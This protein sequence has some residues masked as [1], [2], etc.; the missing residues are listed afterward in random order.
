M[1]YSPF[2]KALKDVQPDELSILRNVSEGWHVEYKSQMVSQNI[3]AKTISSFANQYGGWLILGV[4]E[5]RA[6]HVAGTFPGIPNAQIQGGLESLRNASRDTVRPSIFFEHRI[7]DGPINAIGLAENFSLIVVQIPQGPNTPYVHNDGRIYRRIADS[8]NPKPETDRATLDLLFQRGVQSRS[9]LEEYITRNPTVSEAEDRVPYL[10]LFILSDPFEFQ[11]HW[12]GGNFRDF[13]EVMKLDMLPFNNIF[14]SSQGFVARQTGND[15]YWRSLTWEFSRRCHSFITVPIPVLPNDNVDASWDTFSIGNKFIE[16]YYSSNLAPARI[17][18]LNVMIDLCAA[19]LT[20]HRHLAYK[21]GV[22]GPFFIKARLDDVWRCV[23]FLDL[24]AYLSQI[25]EFGLPIVQ[26]S[27]FMAPVGTSIDSFHLVG[28]T[29]S[30]SVEEERVDVN[31]IMEISPSILMALGISDE[32][33]LNSS[34]WLASR[35]LKNAA[36]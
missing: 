18:D 21:A 25:Y 5:D 11:G 34:G 26:D 7:F 24:P 12:Y 23:P 2:N 15:P 14:P 3:L 16:K 10:H 33:L 36:G 22:V 19:V 32:T 1:Q 17:L 29:R 27:D 6:A 20:R 30:Q 8:S 35:L 4:A 31:D 28:P 9:R 13:S